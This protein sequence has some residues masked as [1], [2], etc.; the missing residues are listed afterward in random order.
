M[1]VIDTEQEYAYLMQND[2]IVV[3]ERQVEEMLQQIF[4]IIHTSR[5]EFLSRL[6]ALP[7]FYRVFSQVEGQY[8]EGVRVDLMSLGPL[9]TRVQE[10]ALSIFAKIMELG[11]FVDKHGMGIRTFNYFP[12]RLHPKRTILMEDDLY[13]RVGDLPPKANDGT[14][15]NVSF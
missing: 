15:P 12:F 6:P 4:E 10:V 8:V 9:K 1:V 2:S 5:P 7:D 13:D 11:L 14:L 3:T